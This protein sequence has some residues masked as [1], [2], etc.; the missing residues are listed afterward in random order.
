MVPTEGR[1]RTDAVNRSVSD[2]G[3]VLHTPGVTKPPKPPSAL[4]EL[5]HGESLCLTIVCTLVGSLLANNSQQAKRA[6]GILSVC[7][8]SREMT[9]ENVISQS[10]KARGENLHF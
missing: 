2:A 10:Q 7:T 8:G 4:L 5:L 1:P 6:T 9:Q 3:G